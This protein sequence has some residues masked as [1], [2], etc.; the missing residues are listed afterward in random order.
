MASE[1][2]TAELKTLVTI[3]VEGL[4][5]RVDATLVE[6]VVKRLQQQG[7]KVVVIEEDDP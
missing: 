2:Q 1:R 4:R 7:A 5:A 6:Q 3:K